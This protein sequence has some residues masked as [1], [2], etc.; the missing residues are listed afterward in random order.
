MALSDDELATFRRL[1]STLGQDRSRLERLNAYYEG[2]QRLEQLG[3]AVPPELRRFVTIVNWPR[4]SADAVGDRLDVEG[5][6][7]AN[8]TRTDDDLWRVWQANDL[9]E[10]SQLAHLDA[11][12]YGRS[13]VCVGS[14]DEDE[15]TPVVTVESPR[16]MV[17]EADPKTRR[18]SAAL[19]IYGRDS[20]APTSPA[21][22]ATLYLPN[23][24]VWLERPTRGGKWVEVDRDEHGMGF[25][26]VVPIVNRARTADRLGVSEMADVIT[27]TDAASRALTNAQ[28]ATET[29]AVPKRFVL[30][31]TKGDF[32]DSK[33]GEVLTAWEAYFGAFSALANE[34][35]DVKQLPAADL[36]NFPTIVNHYAQLVSGLTGLPAAH[37]GF[38]TDNPA[39]ADAIRAS[40]SRLVRK[41]ER[42][43]QAWSGSWEAVMRIV[44][45]IQTGDWDESLQRMETKWRDP[46]TPTEAQKTDAVVKLHSEG[47]LP[48]EAA[49]E[50]LGFSPEDIKHLRELREQEAADSLIEGLLRP[51][52]DEVGNADLGG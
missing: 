38:H 26:P 44:R 36:S 13:F 42:K 5:F 17:T 52:P 1:T 28:L 2:V 50:R 45:R 31:A 10:E 14:N 9:D 20:A 3:L 39:S 30:N 47:I 11:L 43:A 33:T 22:F 7:L 32:V 6:R 19:R 18:V 46:A 23:V 8:Q 12:V 21:G 15:E 29:L 49:W 40:E 48:T 51:T 35:A 34:K 41:C 37:L 25:V 27:L 24:T 4:I 16:E